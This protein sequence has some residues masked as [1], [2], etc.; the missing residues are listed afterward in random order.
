MGTT[1]RVL[2]DEDVDAICQRLTEFS[3]LT[4][5]EHREH[6][7]AFTAYIESQRRKAEFQDK[8]KQQV[9]GW[10]IITVLAG[11]GTAAWNGVR[12]FLE[13]GGS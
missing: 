3:G 1:N 7:T 2:S 10:L 9:G 13:R 6:H 8:V 11:L 12:Y 5:E 4:P